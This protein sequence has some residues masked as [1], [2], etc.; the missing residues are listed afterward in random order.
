MI[1]RRLATAE[2]IMLVWKYNLKIKCQK[3]VVAANISQI[4]SIKFEDE[5][6]CFE[7]LLEILSG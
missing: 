3:I 1:V 4:A 7:I 6:C 2:K 5:Q